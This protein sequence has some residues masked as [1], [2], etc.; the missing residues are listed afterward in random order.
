M[1]LA[2][3]PVSSPRHRSG[4]SVRNPEGP[5]DAVGR[6]FHLRLA[7]RFGHL[8]PRHDVPMNL[9]RA[10]RSQGQ[11]VSKPVTGD[12]YARIGR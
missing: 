5:S 8:L 10:L 1:W 12:A 11:P 4:R 2:R 9:S 6:A 7:C 3:P